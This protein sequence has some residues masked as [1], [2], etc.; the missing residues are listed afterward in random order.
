MQEAQVTHLSAPAH[1]NILLMRM[2]WKGC[3]RMRMWKPSLPQ[4]FTM[5]LLAQIRAASRAEKTTITVA[6]G[7]TF[8]RLQQQTENVKKQS[9]SLELRTGRL[10]DSTS[11][12]QSCWK[13]GRPST[14]TQLLALA[15]AV[16]KPG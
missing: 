16:M 14:S 9:E 6:T 5:Y 13:H 8:P 10:Q 12:A 11:T 1:D 7:V 15:S 2:T 3:R 4:V